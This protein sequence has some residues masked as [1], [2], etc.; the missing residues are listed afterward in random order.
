LFYIL[1][2]KRE[3][4]AIDLRYFR[5]ALKNKPDVIVHVLGKFLFAMDDYSRVLFQEI[6]KEKK[7][8]ISHIIHKLRAELGI[9]GAFKMVNLLEEYNLSLKEDWE[10]NSQLVED[11]AKKE[12]DRVREAISSEISTSEA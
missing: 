6:E 4:Q 10:K 9:L 7:E 12:F 2:E 5:S 1:R 11:T 8:Q 3:D